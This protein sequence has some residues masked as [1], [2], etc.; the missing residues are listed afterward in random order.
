MRVELRGRLGRELPLMM[1]CL[2]LFSSGVILLSIQSKGSLR[3][4]HGLIFLSLFALFLLAVIIARLIINGRRITLSPDG[5]EGAICVARKS[6][7]EAAV[8]KNEVL[9]IKYLD[10]RGGHRQF[11]LPFDASGVD[12]VVLGAAIAR[13]NREP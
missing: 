7:F 1:L 3:P 12:G 5:V 4:T 2:F 9:I 10:H 6:I 13:F 11:V 8:V